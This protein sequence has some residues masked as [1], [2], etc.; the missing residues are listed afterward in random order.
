MTDTQ[1]Q[2]AL[3]DQ[4]ASAVDSP[5]ATGSSWNVP[6]WLADRAME[7]R[8]MQVAAGQDLELATDA[9]VVAYLHTLSLGQPLS[10]EMTRV[11]IWTADRV[12]HGGIRHLMQVLPL[13]PDEQRKLQE[14]RRD[15]RRSTYG[16]GRRDATMKV[17]LTTKA[18]GPVN[19]AIGDD[20]KDPVFHQAPDL[21]AAIVRLPEMIENFREVRASNPLNPAYTAPPAP[22]APA[23]APVAKAAK[24]KSKTAPAAP[25][26][27]AA[28]GEDL[29]IPDAPARAPVMEAEQPVGENAPVDEPVTE[30]DAP[31]AVAAT[32]Q[33]ALVAEAPQ[34]APAARSAAYHLKDGRGPFGTVH[35]ALL[36]MGVSQ[37]EIGKHK[38]WHRLDRLPKSFAEKIEKR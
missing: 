33:T 17:I 20:G 36:A 13:G 7:E 25:Q 30:Q 35:E 10:G 9:E 6:E 23:K 32:E 22:A 1:R 24:G 18:E 3:L 19:V 38:Y 15:I 12:M 14:L 31:A 37:A 34:S 11:M 29:G 28:Q 16:K 21:S 5:V 26:K 4:V 2:K 27:P 8:L